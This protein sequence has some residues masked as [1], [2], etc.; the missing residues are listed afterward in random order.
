MK[1]QE[2]HGPLPLPTLMKCI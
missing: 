1:I 2:G